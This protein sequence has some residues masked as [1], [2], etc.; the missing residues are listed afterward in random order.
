MVTLYLLERIIKE[1]NSPNWEKPNKCHDWKN[2]VP[3]ELI[4]CWNEL[5]KQEKII[6]AYIA[7]LQADAEEW[8]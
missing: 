8:D 7:N 6:I 3:Y 5:T 1:L 2:Y 4:S